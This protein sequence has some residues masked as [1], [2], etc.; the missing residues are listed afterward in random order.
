MV[1]KE[2][3]K[4]AIC[5]WVN[6]KG[7]QIVGDKKY[8]N[9]KFDPLRRLCLCANYLE[10]IHPITNKKISFKLDI[11]KVFIDLLGDIND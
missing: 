6:N 9:S 2:E 4:Y 1:I 8:G 10:I 5:V 7:Y 11:P 3:K